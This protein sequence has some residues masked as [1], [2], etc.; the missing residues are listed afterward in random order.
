MPPNEAAQSEV[1]RTPTQSVMTVTLKVN[2]AP[3][4]F[5]VETRVSLCD[6]LCGSVGL[7]GPSGDHPLCSRQR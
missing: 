7:T 6:A 5:Q 4:T 3:Q 1:S 2:G